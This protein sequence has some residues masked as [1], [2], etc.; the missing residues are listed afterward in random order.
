MQSSNDTQWNPALLGPLDD[1]QDVLIGPVRF[2][3]GEERFYSKKKLGQ[4]EQ[5]WSEISPHLERVLDEDETVL[6]AFPVLHYPPFLQLLGFGWWWQFFFR[7]A[8]VLT[9]RRVV[10]VLMQD[11]KHAGTRVWSYPWAQVRKLK[12]RMGT[13]TM[14]PAK[15][16]TQKW[17]LLERSD[18]KLVKLI[19]PMLEAILP[20]EV[21]VPRPVPVWHCPVCSAASVQHPKVCAHCGTVFKSVGLAA[22]LALAFPGA[23]LFYAGHRVMAAFDF[24][25]EVLLYGL[26][27]VFFLTAADAVEMVVAA[28]LGVFVLFFTKLESVHL[29]TVLVKRT[30]PDP[31]RRNWQRGALGAGVLSAV[32][33]ATPPVFTG[34]WANQLDRDLDF[35]ANTEGWQGGFD[36]E[37]WMYGID[38]DQRSEWIHTDGQALFVW[39]YPLGTAETFEIHAQDFAFGI[40]ENAVEEL[41]IEGFEGFRV[42]EMQADEDGNQLLWIRWVLFD[43]PNSDVHMIGASCAPGEDIALEERVSRLLMTADWRPVE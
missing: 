26:V 1:H 29:S 33:I 8:V 27:T 20:E 14:S 2:F 39:S 36:G 7:A 5:L 23:G 40:G 37:S 21:T 25:G 28:M 41:S 31:S 10:E 12:L 22:G 13:L 42:V 35:S 3:A 43:R 38:L 11:R 4:R 9:D 19:V 18:R 17:R 34:V 32:L 16:R 24:F 15:G 6:A 30:K